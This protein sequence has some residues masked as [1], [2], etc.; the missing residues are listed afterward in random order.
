MMLP[1]YVKTA[2]RNMGKRKLLSFINAFGLSIGIAFCILIYLL[3]KQYVVLAIVAFA[4]AT[5]LSWHAMHQWMTNF[6]YSITI[7]WHIFVLSMVGGLLIA[8]LTVSY[9]AIKSA[10]INPTETLKYE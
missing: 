9:H 5:P 6:Q 10:S 3:N 4:I 8:L 2:G 1:N 7:S